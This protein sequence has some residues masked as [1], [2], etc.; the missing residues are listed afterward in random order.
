M[1]VGQPG[2]AHF[3]RYLT[4]EQQRALATEAID[5]GAGESGFYT[6]IVRGGKPMSVRMMCLGKQ[7]NA[8]TYRYDDTRTDI[9]GLPVMP[10][11]ERWIAI[12]REIGSRAGF[13]FTPD[14]CI[15]NWYRSGSKMGMHQDKDERPESIATGAPVVSISLG[16][17]GRFLFGGLRRRDPVETVML[18]SGDAFV[19]GGAARLRYHGVSRIIA[20]TAPAELGLE[21]RLNLTFRTY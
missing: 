3:P 14:V 4:L 7:W 20:G 8:L 11:P 21:G 16:D 1:D 12:A 13:D 9:D 15:V 19:F 6:P 18:E 5:L 2:V 17:T 10:V